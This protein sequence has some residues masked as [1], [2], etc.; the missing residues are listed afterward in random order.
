MTQ[1]TRQLQPASFRGVPFE[2]SAAAGE[3]GRRVV[4][5]EYPQ[6][7]KPFVEDMGRSAR[8]FTF[9]AFVVGT[10]YIQKAEKLI[11]ALETPGSGKLIHPWMGEMEVSIAA[12]SKVNFDEKLGLASV[13]ITVVESG[14]LEFPST[15]KDSLSACFGA[16]DTLCG[17]AIERFTSS[18]DLSLVSGYVDSALSGDLLDVLGVVSNCELA[19]AFDFADSVADLASKGLSLLST[20]PRVFATTLAGALG[21]SRWATS[22]SAWTGV[23]KQLKNLVGNDK[24]SSG[25]KE[26]AK[27]IAEGRVLSD[28]RKA[29]MG[30][31]AALET[32]TRQVL[33]AQVVGVSTRVSSEL[34]SSTPGASPSTDVA[35]IDASRPESKPIRSYDEVVAVRDELTA[36]LDSEMLLETDDVVY[37]ALEESRVAVFETLTQSADTMSRLVTVTP[38]D[39]TPA[40]V[41]AYDYHDDAKR[42]IEIAQRNGVP[43]EG[44]CP[45]Q[46]LKVLSE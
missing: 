37:Q 32:L 38:A 22:V 20:D 39:V 16:A 2:V 36:S 33:L 25:T 27:A 13:V 24:L 6:R 34:D 9:T 28:A 3:F 8:R 23:A 35:V 31:R 10:D 46:P 26:R 40:L 15:A 11:G 5:H 21:L 42:D 45:A 29:V 4:V 19:K 1:L 18:I 7:D 14:Q 17:A 41:L 44:F 43:R 30:N 12:N